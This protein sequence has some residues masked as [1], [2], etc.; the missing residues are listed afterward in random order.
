MDVMLGEEVDTGWEASNRRAYG[1][2][3]RRATISVIESDKA[4]KKQ[5]QVMN[6]FVWPDSIQQKVSDRSREAYD[7]LLRFKKDEART[8]LFERTSDGL[9]FTDHYMALRRRTPTAAPSQTVKTPASSSKKRQSPTAVDAASA[10]SVKRSAKKPRDEDDSDNESSKKTRLIYITEGVLERQM[11]IDA[12]LSRY[13]CIIIDEA[14]K[15]GDQEAR[16]SR[17]E[18]KGCPVLEFEGRSFPVEIFYVFEDDKTPNVVIRAVSMVTHIHNKNEDDGDVLVFLPGE[19][20]IIRAYGIAARNIENLGV[21]ALYAGIGQA[22][23]D[24]AMSENK[25][26]KRRVTFATNIAPTPIPA[27]ARV[28]RYVQELVPSSTNQ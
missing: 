27:K 14:H 28:A 1:I 3:R 9:T 7:Y 26:G 22:L 11:L 23:Q 8:N 4:L 16:Q 19:A 12:S 20:E 15:S 13:C 2:P 17:E 25:T 5:V 18:G 24:A 10:T 6:M 21:L